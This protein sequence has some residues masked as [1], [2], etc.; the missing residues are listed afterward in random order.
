M[1]DKGAAIDAL[2]ATRRVT[3]L[4]QHGGYETL[5]PDSSLEPFHKRGMLTILETNVPPLRAHY[6]AAS[7]PEAKRAPGARRR[8]RDFKAWKGMPVV[9]YA[10][11]KPHQ[12]AENWVGATWRAEA[13]RLKDEMRDFA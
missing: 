10:G 11:H 3:E 9:G 7:V 1:P 8:N 4:R 6:R 2:R 12:R 13:M 5:F